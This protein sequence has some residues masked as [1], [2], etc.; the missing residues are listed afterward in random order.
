VNFIIGRLALRKKKKR[1]KRAYWSWRDGSAV[2]TALP[3]DP[4]SIPG[5]HMAAHNCL[6][7]QF[8]GL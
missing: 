4:G 3:E 2:L 8:Q 5:T 1:K 7:L 6:Y